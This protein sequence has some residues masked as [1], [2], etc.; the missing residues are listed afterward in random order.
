MEDLK[1]L[2]RTQEREKGYVNN[3]EVS[4]I[5]ASIIGTVLPLKPKEPNTDSTQDEH[6]DNKAMSTK[7]NKPQEDKLKAEMAVLK[8]MIVDKEKR[9][10]V[11]KLEN[12]LKETDFDEVIHQYIFR[13]IKYFYEMRIDSFDIEKFK[14]HFFDEELTIVFNED[15]SMFKYLDKEILYQDVVNSDFLKYIARVRGK[16]EE[17]T[18]EGKSSDLKVYDDCV[19]GLSKWTFEDM[20]KAK[21]EGVEDETKKSV[22][23]GFKLFWLNT[24][25]SKQEPEAQPLTLPCG[26]LSVIAGKSEHGKT[27]LLCNVSANILNSG[28]DVIFIALEETETDTR[29]KIEAIAYAKDKDK[30]LNERGTLYIASDKYQITKEHR[31]FTDVHSLS[32]AIR[33]AIKANPDVKPAIICIDYFQKMKGKEDGRKIPDNQKDR[34]RIVSNQLRLLAQ[35]VKTPVLVAAQ[36]GRDVSSWEKMQKENIADAAEIERT[37]TT[38]I[39]VWNH[40]EDITCISKKNKKTGEPY[41]QDKHNPSPYITL[42]ILKNKTGGANRRN[43]HACFKFD[44]CTSSISLQGVQDV[45]DKD[46]IKEGD[47][48]NTQEGRGAIYGK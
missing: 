36:V 5:D 40:L 47:T 9:D 15:K 12:P 13:A 11:W 19:F 32:E 42:K 6:K 41:F 31:D 27:T 3:G 7:E 1:D 48:P 23:T 20:K 44:D 4:Q 10:L 34:M 28:D 43:G 37:A 35:D 29:K 33:D 21:D 25:T 18:Q 39:E 2:E 24:Q 14:K 46:K 17:D 45:K 16:K 30:P 26:E 22:D 8:I 38:I